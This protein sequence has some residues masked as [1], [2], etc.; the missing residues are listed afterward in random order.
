MAPARRGVQVQ[1]TVS[2]AVVM[3][4]ATGL[5]AAFFIATH[6]RQT[7]RLQPMLGRVL[8]EEARRLDRIQHVPAPGAT[9][10]VA[11]A[12]GQTRRAPGGG[13]AGHRVALGEAGLALAALARVEG[14]ALLRAGVPWD[15]I[16]F[17]APIEGP[18]GGE[19]AVAVVSPAVPRL[20]FAGLLLADCLAFTV[21]GV[22]LLRRR[23]VAPLRRLADAARSIGTAGAGVRVDIEGVG[24]VGEVAEV[25]Q[26]FNEMSEALELRNGA[27]EKAVAELRTVNQ[28]L[29]R[30]RDGLDRAERMAAVGHLAAG[31]AHEVGNPMGAVLAFLDLAERDG[32]LSDA[33]RSH[34]GRATE[35]GERVREILRQ[36][37]DFSRPP[38]PA[39]RPVDLAA[40]AEQALGLV[41][42]QA[43]YRNVD[44]ELRVEPGLGPVLAD[45]SL[46]A[47][48]LLNLVLNAGDA[49]LSSE[50]RR[51]EISV[52]SSPLRVRAGDEESAGPALSRR[53][54]DAV[55]CRVEDSGPGVS[56]EDRERIFDPFYTTKPPGEGTGL[57]LANALRLTEELGGVLEQRDAELGGAAF[58]LR[59]PRVAVEAGVGVRVNPGSRTP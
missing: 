41:H 48:I 25:G 1:V 47:Q 53:V 8:A 4:T 59:L 22:Y 45:E 18:T 42:A 56:P 39:C 26:A 13:E 49:A 16:L 20:A 24:G 31:V 37:L 27:L 44:F 12:D 21:L 30:A 50:V 40:S 36:L 46:V 14:R 58:L 3:V 2:L 29:K 9:W 38:R 11:L 19:V 17:A 57:G 35:Q 15:P 43:R 51:V 33:A 23:V 54:H 32:S 10:F 55:E 7:E 5:L 28:R 6:A 52:A 34:V